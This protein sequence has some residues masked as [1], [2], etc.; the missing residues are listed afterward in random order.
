M[1]KHYDT[2][3]A[4]DLLGISR[5]TLERWRIE[6]KGPVYRKFGKRAMYAEPDLLEWSEA[7]RRTSTTDVG[8]FT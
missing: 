6:G 2:P 3:Q 7:Q 5:R 4:A 8:Q 1:M